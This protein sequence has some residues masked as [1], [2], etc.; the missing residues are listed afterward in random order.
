MAWQL[1]LDPGTASSRYG[2]DAKTK[3]ISWTSYLLFTHEHSSV[4]SW[5]S[6]CNFTSSTSWA[7]VCVVKNFSIRMCD[8]AFIFR[9][10]CLYLYLWVSDSKQQQQQNLL[11]IFSKA[12]FDFLHCWNTALSS[13][14]LSQTAWS[15]VA[16]CTVLAVFCLHSIHLTVITYCP[17]LIVVW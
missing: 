8:L 12:L 11:F 13:H 5:P 3:H 14:T 9:R 2:I 10:A 4:A 17:T 7:W 16:E 15:T 6:F 1:P